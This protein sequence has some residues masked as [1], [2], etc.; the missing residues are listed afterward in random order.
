M[1]F[2]LKFTMVALIALNTAVLSST[3]VC[4]QDKTAPAADDEKVQLSKALKM[5]ASLGKVDAVKDLLKQG[6]DISWRDPSDNGKTPLTKSVLAGRLEVVKLLLASGA[7]IHYPDG[8][9]RYPIYFTC[10]GNNVELLQFLLAQG[11]NEDLNKGPFPILVS[12]CDHGQALPEFIPIM[13]KAG[14]DPNALKGNVTPLIAAIQ[15][16][17]KIRRPEI[18]R[19]YVQALLDNQA[20]VNLKDKK[21]KSPLQWAKE[22]G[23][24]QIIEMLEKAGGK[25]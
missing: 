23:D 11:G 25:E 14:A 24:Q 18:A 12:V 19:S 13:V 22:R 8:S 10:I 21:G 2:A 17:P 7:D 5:A 3:T 1:P 4:A 9:G 6:A 20:D 15:L 16:D